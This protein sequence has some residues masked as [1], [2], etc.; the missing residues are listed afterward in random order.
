MLHRPGARLK[1]QRISRL[2]EGFVSIHFV[3]LELKQDAPTNTVPMKQDAPTNTVPM[4]RK[5]QLFI[6]F[7]TTELLHLNIININ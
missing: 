3:A 1:S 5:R 4:K 2:P 7:H 6:L